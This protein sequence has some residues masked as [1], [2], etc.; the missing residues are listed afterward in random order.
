MLQFKDHAV[1]KVKHHVD[2]FGEASNKVACLIDM[3]LDEE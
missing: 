3:R 1:I 2:G